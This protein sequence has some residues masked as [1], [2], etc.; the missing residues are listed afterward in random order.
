MARIEL[1]GYPT[2]EWS[3]GSDVTEL[4][5]AR[6]RFERALQFNADNRTA[7]HRLGLMAM[8]ERDYESAQGYLYPAYL[9]DRGH[10]GIRKALMYSYVW[11]DK[12]PQALPLLK[13]YP[14][15]TAE[16]GVYQWWWGQRGFPHLSR[17]AEDAN[18]QLQA[19]IPKP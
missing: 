6:M 18:I 9:L 15:A 2:G 19:L 10:R 8:L 5:L 13:E 4:G 1:R 7:L 16:L 14:E 17:L 3:D 12:I 11:S